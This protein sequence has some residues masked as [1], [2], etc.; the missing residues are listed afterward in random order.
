MVKHSVQ[1][2][3]WVATCTQPAVCTFVK[4]GVWRQLLIMKAPDHVTNFGP[5]EPHVNTVYQI[6]I[7]YTFIT[8]I[9]VSIPVFLSIIFPFPLLYFLP[10]PSNFYYIT[11]FVLFF[12]C[13]FYF[14]LLSFLFL[15]TVLFYFILFF[16][17]CSCSFF[18]FY[19]FLF[20]FNVLFH[21][22]LFLMFLFLIFP[23]LF[24]CTILLFRRVMFYNCFCIFNVFL[25]YLYYL[26]HFILPS[27]QFLSLSVS[28]YYF[29]VIYSIFFFIF[30]S[31]FTS[32]LTV[33]HFN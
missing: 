24:P 27:P 26:I 8:H 22:I 32:Q 17:F 33:F 12:S 13:V 6:S 7:S 5:L 31:R 3:I 4:T 21:F 1:H 14:F 18:H 19:F 10:C 2:I 25:I 20:V 29:I 11:F 9:K 28:P 15:F 16:L 23:S 30:D